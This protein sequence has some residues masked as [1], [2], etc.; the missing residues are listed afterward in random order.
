M[1]AG[2][3]RPLPESGTPFSYAKAK[4][5]KNICVTYPIAVCPEQFQMTFG[6]DG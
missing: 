1:V 5:K 6:L 3:A 4:K 2:T